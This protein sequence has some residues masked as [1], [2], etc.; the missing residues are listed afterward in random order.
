M[1][2]ESPEPFPFGTSVELRF[3]LPALD[4]DSE[5][6]ATVRWNTEAAVG[7]QFDSPRAK[8]VWAMNKLFKTLESA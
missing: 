6:Q 8:E 5:I 2:I 1:L 7:V 3:R 4:S